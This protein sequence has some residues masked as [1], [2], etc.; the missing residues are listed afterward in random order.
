MRIKN[1]NLITTILQSVAV[2]LLF[3]PGFWAVEFWKNLEWGHWTQDYIEHVSM[4]SG[5]DYGFAAQKSFPLL[6]W[7]ALYLHCF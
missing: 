6:G 4:V 1:R 2:L 7:L 3:V 5:F